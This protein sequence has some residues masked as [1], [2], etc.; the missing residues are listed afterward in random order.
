MKKN[1]FTFAELLAMLVVLGILMLIA[2]PNISGM[3]K[4]QRV[5]SLKADLTN[6]VET[7]KIKGSKENIKPK[8]G[9]C[10]VFTLNYLNDD[11]NIEKGPNGGLYN[12]FDSLVLYTREG[13]RYKY[14]VRLLESYKEKYTGISFRDGEVIKNIENSDIETIENEIGLTKNDTL[15]TAVP[16]L[17]S[18]GSISSKC[19]SGIKGYYSGE[20][21]CTIYNGHYYDANGNAVSEN[22]YKASCL[23]CTI[24]D[25]EYYDNR[26]NVVSEEEYHE[27]C[28]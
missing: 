7:A 12:Q 11:G 21:G 17:N 5:N 1:G 22:Q 23:R 19:S 2:I 24:Y 27:L 25:G 20:A 10:Y 4:N 28:S 16:K 9:E 13:S 14:Y 6:M 18:F 3:L 8:N 15:A 26:G